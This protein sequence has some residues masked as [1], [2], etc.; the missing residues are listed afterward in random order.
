MKKTKFTPVVLIVLA[1]ALA[2]AAGGTYAKYAT[3]KTVEGTFTVTADLGSIAMDKSIITGSIIPGVDILV[4]HDVLVTE[5]T[6]I[7]AYVYLVLDINITDNTLEFHPSD[8]SW[9]KI[10]ETT[11]D[12]IKTIAYVYVDGT[13]PIEV[14]D[15]V[16]IPVDGTLVVSQHFN[17]SNKI[18]LNFSAEMYQTAAGNTAKEVYKS[19]NPPQQS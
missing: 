5:K 15:D 17:T 19:F 3:T 16:T 2:M 8:E 12:G 11:K 7:P 4:N 9:E 18:N 1:L 13:N 6:S 14:K 10:S